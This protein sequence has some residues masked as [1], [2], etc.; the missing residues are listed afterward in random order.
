MSA[1]DVIGTCRD[2][3][4]AGIQHAI[5]NMTNVHEIESLETFGRQIIPTVAEL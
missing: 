5:F 3:A 1:D 4:G 2:L